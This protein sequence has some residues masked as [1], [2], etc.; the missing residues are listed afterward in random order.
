VTLRADFVR[1]PLGGPLASAD[2][3][4]FSFVAAVVGSSK[5]PDAMPPSAGTA[6]EEAARTKLLKYT[7][8][9]V[10][11]D[12]KRVIPL[13]DLDNMCQWPSTFCTGPRTSAA[14]RNLRMRACAISPTNV[15][16][17]PVAWLQPA[18]P[19]A[20]LRGVESGYWSEITVNMESGGGGGCHGGGK[21]YPIH[22]CLSPRP[23]RTVTNQHQCAACGGTKS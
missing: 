6:A 18:P 9:M 2:S 12:V 3:Y 8:G 11:P 23:A 7:N 1:L 22:R 5:S 14:D 20:R 17:L 10:G 13:T 21:C 15:L 19:P 16:P 4:D